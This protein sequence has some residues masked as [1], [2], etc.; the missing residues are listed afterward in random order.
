MKFD[1]KPDYKG[2]KS[3][4]FDVLLR[5]T[6]I[7]RNNIY[8]FDWFDDSEYITNIVSISRILIFLCILIYFII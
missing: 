6:P 3:L 5:Y 7:P 8:N 2:L 4:L 1:D